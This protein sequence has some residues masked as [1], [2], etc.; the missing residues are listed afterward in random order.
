MTIPAYCT[1]CS[2]ELTS[3]EQVGLTV[4]SQRVT[5]DGTRP[6]WDDMRLSG[7]QTYVTGYRCTACRH[8][9]S[10][11]ACTALAKKLGTTYHRI[12]MSKE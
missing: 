11:A 5:L 6:V 2:R 3:V 10:Q 12:E 9:L 7:E 4:S 1:R 8:K